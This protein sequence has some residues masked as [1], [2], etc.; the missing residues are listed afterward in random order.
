MARLAGRLDARPLSTPNLAPM[1]GVLL[2]LFAGFVGLSGAA[3]ATTPLDLPP[4][5]SIY[6]G[7]ARHATVVA[8]QADGSLLLD[9]RAIGPG[10]LDEALVSLAAADRSLALWARSDVDYGVIAPLVAAAGRAGVGVE[11]IDERSYGEPPNRTV[12]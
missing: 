9:G 10:A 12:R 7:P 5:A 8:V 4:V 1:I 3:E 2:A 6:C 11:L